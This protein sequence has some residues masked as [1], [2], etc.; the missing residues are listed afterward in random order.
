MRRIMQMM[1]MCLEQLWAFNIIHF[2]F[3]KQNEY[4][5]YKMRLDQLNRLLESGVLVYSNN[6]H[7]RVHSE[8]QK[9]QASAYLMQ[10]A[11]MI[12]TGEVSITDPPVF[13]LTEEFTPPDAN[14]MDMPNEFVHTH[15]PSDDDSWLPNKHC[16]G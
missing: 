12:F 15:F 9:I 16:S 4:V 5:I 3:F 2:Y 10:P 8:G 14:P 6:L 11:V 7:L 13:S 1:R